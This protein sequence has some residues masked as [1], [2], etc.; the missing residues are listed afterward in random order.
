MIKKNFYK[1]NKKNLF[2]I[3]FLIFISIFYL[4]IIV[5]FKKIIK[6]ETESFQKYFTTFSN[7]LQLFDAG[8]VHQFNDIKITDVLPASKQ[9]LLVIFDSIF[10]NNKNDLPDI[11]IF[12]KFKN[13][14]KIYGDRSK[15]ISLGLNYKPKYVPCKISDGVKLL[16]CKV[17]LKGDLSEHWS[18]KIRFSMRIKVKDGFIF[19][20]QD[21][22]I[23]KPK[24]RQFPYDQTFAIAH[25]D[26][27]GLSSNKQE[28]FNIKLNNENWGV[29]N[30]EPAIDDKFIEQNGI[31]RS[32]V[33]RISNQDKWIYSEWTNNSNKIL[34]ENHFI[35][36]P[37][38][39]FSQ[40]GNET[41]ILNNE[42]SRE[43]YSH[44]FHSINS[45]SFEIFDRKKMVDAF[46]H[47]LVWGSFHSL[48]NSNSFYTW[49]SYTQK[50]EPILTDQ[51]PWR[52]IEEIIKK[53]KNSEF[54][55]L[56]PYEYKE[57]FRQ[58]SITKKE[59]F[60]SLNKI[61]DYY[62]LNNPVKLVNK[63]SDKYFQN[64]RIKKI[65]PIKSNL[66]FLS[67]KSDPVISWI[68]NRSI[69]N[70]FKKESIPRNY[71]YSDELKLDQRFLKLFHFDDGTIKIFNLLPKPILISELLIEKK[72]IIINKIIPSSKKNFLSKIELSTSFIGHYDN[73]ISVIARL[74]DLEKKFSN[75]FTITNKKKL[76]IYKDDFKNDICNYDENKT[77]CYISGINHI[78]KS[79]VF[80]NKAI[81][82]EG[83][84]LILSNNSDLIFNSSASFNGSKENPISVSGQGGLIIL[85]QAPDH[86]L[87]NIN[88]VNFNDL[89]NTSFPLM[90]LSG[91]VNVYGGKLI[92]KNSSFY[93]GNAEDQLNIVNSEIDISNLFFNNSKSDGFDCD[94][95]K[96][97]ISNLSFDKIG[98]DALDISGSDIFVIDLTA[99]DVR[100][101][102]ISIGEKSNVTMS[103]ILI[104]NVNTGIAVK[105][106]SKAK[107]NKIHLRN[108]N[109]DSFMT[110]NKKPY[111]KGTTFLEVNNLADNNKTNNT[112]FCVREKDT[113][114]KINNVECKETDVNI[115]YLYKEGRMKK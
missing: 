94:Y 93:N 36:D 97:A 7:P 42:I 40:R 21:F 22:S 96:G 72:K 26:L 54:S 13:L 66:N 34:H 99:N 33:F 104:T 64:D 71:S 20:L 78:N 86:T 90:K 23:Q 59:Y 25:N 44:I 46:V 60:D 95:C 63:I 101:K 37:T 81:I 84:Q 112:N 8:D 73:K 31:K 53:D 57:L 30:I 111:F 98:G 52:N 76:N 6:N 1:P 12:I 88:Y 5:D 49:N 69:H 62:S 48:F 77:Y 38:I 80:T 106:G 114:A 50:L 82:K 87:S 100:D 15:A 17:R 9:I 14:N 55:K 85:N 56:L 16:K 92:L 102:A 47:S 4:G 108:I 83:A 32:G 43:I 41:K 109:Y 91:S 107:I 35:S 29:M 24:A 2:T 110:Y 39:F 67:K 65:S 19:G 28:F 79:I 89:Y 18:E 115:K 70:E 58:K 113:L 27:G 75:S 45:K 105:D 51:F 3:I 10:K 103:D 61:K 11:K 68:N 74:E